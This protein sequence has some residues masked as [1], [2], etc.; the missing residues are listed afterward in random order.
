MSSYTE[1]QL[2]TYFEGLT[3]AQK[4]ELVNINKAWFEDVFE[5][6]HKRNCYVSY[7]P[8]YESEGTNQLFLSLGADCCGGSDKHVPYFSEGNIC[9][10]SSLFNFDNFVHNGSVSDGTLTLI[11]GQTIT[12]NASVC[13]LAKGSLHVRFNGF[14][15]VEIGHYNRDGHVVSDGKES[16]WFSSYF[17]NAAPTFVITALTD[18]TI[19][20][21]NWKSSKC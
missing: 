19:T 21:I 11:A 3:N 10:F 12:V 18:T 16:M 6:I 20:S 5:E 8:C 2:R 7:A 13:E 9:N 1:N 15:N 4:I 17:L 14:V